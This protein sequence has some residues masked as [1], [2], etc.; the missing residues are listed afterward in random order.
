MIVALLKVTSWVVCIVGVVGRCVGFRGGLV[1]KLRI[2]TD[3]G[4]LGGM[5]G[6]G[7]GGGGIVLVTYDGVVD[8]VV[9]VAVGVVVAIGGRGG[10]SPTCLFLCLVC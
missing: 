6:R 3:N 1:W 9:G 7:V 4:D 2:G 8:R 5:V 10:V